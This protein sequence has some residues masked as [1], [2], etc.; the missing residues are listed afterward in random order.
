MSKSINCSHFTVISI[1]L[2][3]IS[4][5]FPQLLLPCHMP[6]P[7]IHIKTNTRKVDKQAV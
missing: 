1:K 4:L 6:I 3:G 5:S 7:L 2:L